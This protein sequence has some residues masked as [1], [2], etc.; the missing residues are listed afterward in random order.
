M[1]LKRLLL[2]VVCMLLLACTFEGT[3][4]ASSGANPAGVTMREV[5]GDFCPPAQAMKGN[6]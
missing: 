3:G 1:F 6:C 4:V 2:S 5:V